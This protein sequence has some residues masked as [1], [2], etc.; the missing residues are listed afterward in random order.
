MEEQVP[1]AD[2]GK[3]N[4]HSREGQASVAWLE[5]SVQL[6]AQVPKKQK[7]SE[8]LLM[9]AAAG[10]FRRVR[11][12]VGKQALN[13]MR[14]VVGEPFVARGPKPLEV[15]YLAR[16]AETKIEDALRVAC[17]HLERSMLIVAE[18]LRTNCRQS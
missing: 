3:M 9:V 17:H 11:T 18:V 14:P 15:C 13:W 10:A 4:K 2:G 6:V 1:T 7:W 16:R 8:K 5:D 12:L